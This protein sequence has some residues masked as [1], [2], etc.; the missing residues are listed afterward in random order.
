[1]IRLFVIFLMSLFKK[2]QTIIIQN[3]KQNPKIF[4]GGSILSIIGWIISRKYVDTLYRK[5]RNYPPGPI[6]VPIFGCL[7]YKIDT[8]FLKRLSN[9]YGAV[10]TVQMGFRYVT[11]I[12]DCD[13]TLKLFKK[14]EFSG[15]EPTWIKIK[16]FPLLNGEAFIERR[17][18][19]MKTFVSMINSNYINTFGD[20]ILQSYLFKQFDQYANTKQP[21]LVVSHIQ[22][23]GMDSIYI[24]D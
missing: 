7:F 17:K 21:L 2:L 10:A 23:I 19:F 1:M 3:I 22:Y 15:R 4:I 20:D 13:L 18:L 5:I 6:G 16:A 9:D 24:A 11:Y 14:M 12:N 8:E